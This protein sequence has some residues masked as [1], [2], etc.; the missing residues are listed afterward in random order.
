VRVVALLPHESAADP[1][2]DDQHTDVFRALLTAGHLDDLRIA[3]D[4]VMPASLAPD[5][6]ILLVSDNDLG[7][8]DPEVIRLLIDMVRGQE[9]P[10]A[11]ATRPV[12]DTIKRVGPDGTLHGTWERDRLRELRSPLCCRMTLATRLGR[13]PGV[14]DLPPDDVRLVADTPP[15]RD[16]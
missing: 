11:L 13:I 10:A 6:E 16:S 3:D 4:T 14:A 1:L 15:T 7:L 8:A 9:V 12:T 5:A 2:T